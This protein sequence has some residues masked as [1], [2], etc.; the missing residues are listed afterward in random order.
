MTPT[1]GFSIGDFISAIGQQAS[2]ASYLEHLLTSVAQ[3]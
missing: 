3:D 1:F 2:M